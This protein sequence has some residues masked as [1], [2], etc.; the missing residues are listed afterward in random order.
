MSEENQ[1]IYQY[2]VGGA[3]PAD[4]L[5]YVSRQADKQLYDAIKAGEFCYVLNARQMGK[6]SLQARVKE[7]LDL[8][9]FACAIVDLTGIGSLG[10]TPAQWYADLIDSLVSKFHL[11]EKFDFDSWWEKYKERLSP[12]RCLSKFIDEILLEE[13][14]QKIVIFIDEIDSILS[15][16]V[17]MDDFFAFIRSCYNERS[18]NSKYNRLTFVLLGVAT[19]S[20]LIR[21]KKRT[22]FNIG[23]AIDLAGFQLDEAYPLAE[24]FKE[25]VENPVVI[26]KEILQWT[27]GQP[28]LTQ[29]LSKL[30]SESN[31]HISKGDE[32][33]A[34]SHLVR[35]EIVGDWKVKDQQE[36]FKTIQDR[37]LNNK[38][39]RF[40]ILELYKKLLLSSEIGEDESYEQIV[41]RLSGLVIKREGK[42]RIANRIYEAIFNYRWAEEMLEQLRAS[43]VQQAREDF[44]HYSYQLG[45]SLQPD[46][47]SYIARLADQELYEGLKSGELC[48]VLNSRQM[49]KSSLRIQT[50]RRLQIEGIACAS[51]DMTSFGIQI[52]SE[53]WYASIVRSLVRAF[54]SPETF[55]LRDWWLTNDFLSPVQRLSTFIRDI[56][57]ES[58][59]QNI[60]IFIDEIDSILGLQFS[61]DDFFAFI[62][63]CY[64]RRAVEPEYRRLTFALIGVATP[65]ELIQD[66][67]RTPFNIGRAIDLQGFQIQEA[68]SLTRGFLAKAQ[69]PDAVLQA[70]LIWTGGQ[71]FL[72]QK[73][74]HLIRED[75]NLIVQGDELEYVSNLIQ[76]KLIKNWEAQDQPDHLRTIRDRLLSRGQRVSR[77][78]GIY[79]QIVLQGEII[80]DDS[81]E[82]IELRLSGLVVKRQGKLKVYNQIYQSIFDKNWIENSLAQLRPYSELIS[83]WLASGCQDESRLLRGQA[84]QDALSWAT[85]KRLSDEDYQFLAASQELEKHEVQRILKVQQQANA[86]LAEAQSKASQRV[87]IGSIVL[88]LALIGTFLSISTAVQNIRS[89]TDAEMQLKQAQQKAQLSQVQLK[90]AQQEVQQLR[91]E[92]DKLQ[93]QKNRLE[94]GSQPP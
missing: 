33:S 93:K 13:L 51:I 27:G 74:C 19:P 31:L 4:S 30:V 68:L 57:L 90:K 92:I 94:A 76:D 82:E 54:N 6:S 50:I 67:S 35:A 45:G 28:I 60:V 52:T 26:L 46:S 53:Q 81:L 56:L 37:I 59:S 75:K 84:L 8:D 40:Q 65:S 63:D 47:P 86:I 87:R 80:A 83:A 91:E 10:I 85:D 62:R 79:Q 77:L 25:K 48:Y 15:L 70:I 89:A 34:I 49:G 38:E 43:G 71:P 23:K 29:R 1:S 44:H 11:F 17:P 36:H 7:Q 24:G 12:M 58:I 73:V 22:P 55:N 42:L 39:V 2:Q 64:N 9:G 88:V 72:T 21:D 66:K 18:Y 69:K 5:T 41:L 3:L 14:C 61:T 20:D 78:L 16:G 32:M